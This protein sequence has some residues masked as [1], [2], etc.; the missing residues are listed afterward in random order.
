MT[1]HD[2]AA[3]GRA[4]PARLRPADIFRISG[5]GLRARKLRAGLSA[6]GIAIGI[7]AIVS[8]LGVSASSQANLLAELGRLG[9]LLTVSPGQALDGTPVPLPAT[10]EPMIRAIPPVLSVAGVADL[11]N[12]AVYRSAAIP[13]VDSG[14]II[15]AGSDTGLLR[16]LGGSVAH[17]EFLNPANDRFPVVVLGWSAARIL[18]V[19]DLSRPTQVFISGSYFTVVGILRP[20]ALVPEIDD[21]V[22]VGFPIAAS[23]LGYDSGPTTVYLRSYPSQVDAVRG[24]LA[25]TANPAQPNAVQVSRPSDVLIAR[26]AAAGALSNLV[27][28]LGLVAVLIGGVGVANVMLISVLE[29]RGEIGLRR[30]VGATSGQIGVQFLTEALLLAVLGGAAGIGLGAAAS[31][32]YAL[33]SSQ[34]IAIPAVAVW[35]GLGAALTVGALAGLYPALRAARLAPADALRAL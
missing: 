9:N 2:G 22:L 19:S 25:A 4:R 5:S 34:P 18:G 26:A 11:P 32:C 16:T 6:L 20:V 7:A 27:L 28:G 29:R 30:A 14:G 17:G 8:V 24:V 1:D 21:S 12:A 13:S 35:A 10:A 31:A 33:A 23:L 15:V 3:A